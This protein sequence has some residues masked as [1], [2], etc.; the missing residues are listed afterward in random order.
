VL[1]SEAPSVSDFD[2]ADLSR[3]SRYTEELNKDLGELLGQQFERSARLL[4]ASGKDC[5]RD[6]ACAPTRTTWSS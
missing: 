3:S 1:V 4:N 6:I 5:R 2:S